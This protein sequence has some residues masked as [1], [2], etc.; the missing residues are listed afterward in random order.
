MLLFSLYLLINM[1]WT[2]EIVQLGSIYFQF[3]IHVEGELMDWKIMYKD[4]L[5]D[6]LP[7]GPLNRGKEFF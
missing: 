2:S 1:S 6:F 3:V 7:S 4:R 5:A